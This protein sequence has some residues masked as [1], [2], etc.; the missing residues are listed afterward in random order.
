MEESL[1]RYI[2][3]HFDNALAQGHIQAYYQPVIR[4]ISGQLCSFEALARW[5]DPERGLLL[6][7]DFIPVLEQEKRIHLLDVSII[8]QV[9]AR[10][11]RT[12][13]AGETPI[14]VSINLSRL[15]FS[16]CDIFSL[17]DENVRACQIPH[18]FLYIEITES[19]LAEQEG[20][21]R[22][23]VDRFHEAGYQVWM[24][25]FGSGYSSL[26]MLKDYSFDELKLDM[27]FLS[28][29]NQ[30]S[31]RILTSVIHMAKE[32]D[33]HTLAEGVETEEQFQYLR[34]IGCE[35]VQGYY[36][37]APK[38]YDE[39]LAD[40]RERGIDIELPRH[41]R[42][43]DEIGAV[44]FL[45]SVP[46]MDRLEKQRLISGR[47]LNS[48]PLALVELRPDAM[49]VLFINAAFEQNLTR[50]EAWTVLQKDPHGGA[51]SLSALPVR[52]RKLLDSTRDRGTGHMIF[53]SHDEYYEVKT[54][55][56]T[57]RSDAFCVLLQLNNL[58]EVSRAASTSHLDEGLRQMYTLFDRITLVDLNTNRIKPLYVGLMDYFTTGYTDIKRLA[59]EFAERW[60]FPE[61]REKYLAL[62]DTDTLAERI[63]AAHSTSVCGFIRCLVVNGEYEWK[64]IVLL[65]Y[66]PDVYF[67]LI[68]DAHR[69]LAPFELRDESP[70]VPPEEGRLPALL[71]KNLVRSD[72]VRMFWKDRARRFLG[73]N[74]G[75]LDYYGFAS[76]QELVGKTD[77]DLGWHV[78]PDPYM[79]DELRVIHEGVTTHNIPGRCISNGENREI[80]ANKTP[81]YNEEGCIIGLLGCFIDRDLLNMN[82]KRGVETSSRDELTGLLNSRGLSEQVHAFKDEYFLRNT[83]FMRLHI[84]IDDLSEINREYGFD[85]G[86]RMIAAL[87]VRLKKSFGTSSAIGRINGYEFVL[88]HQIRDRRE[89]EEIP[90]AV[91]QISD[92]IKEIDGTPITIYLSLGYA[93]FS[94]SED[95][96]ELMQ[97]AQ[98]RLLADH[99]DHAPV[100]SYRSVSSGFFRLYDDLPIAYAVYRIRTSRG[101]KHTDAVLFYANHVFE[102][103]AG[104]PLKDMLGLSVRDLFP[105]LDESWHD[106]ARRSALHGETVTGSIRNPSDEKQYYIT[107]HQIIHPGYC[108]FTYQELDS[109]GRPI[110][111]GTD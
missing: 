63:D 22:S 5:V 78:H 89:L 46:F 13:I 98:M 60:V 38:P 3:E 49:A 54:K 28:S 8:R 86:D 45:S 6:P 100:G 16:L 87:G 111:P 43:Y 91:R 24:D 30:R 77:E 71:W 69:E 62:L 107:A 70:S 2:S 73:A 74:Q 33:I 84:S 48:I 57:S 85:F 95:A 4:S 104:R 20:H 40:L 47:Q 59:I 58:S 37:G 27:R 94:E 106:I 12:V 97:S 61:D 93:L 26:N 15:D 23:V 19:V 17:V 25:D 108:C 52:V 53:V 110:E 36:F 1:K 105:Q 14:P 56:I 50:L 32:I 72:V 103:R 41:R 81:L 99:D 55:L 66:R 92:S 109:Q 90:S 29:F 35:K 101:A 96:D 42:Y 18:D 44:N 21:M 102:R 82:D 75:F 68:R 11:R 76:A 34:N 10:L 31:R 39:A 65:R 83:D 88:L 64:Q 51:F 9:C 79:N 7:R 80:L 67:E